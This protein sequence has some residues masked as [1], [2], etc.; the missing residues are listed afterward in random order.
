MTEFEV[1]RRLD[2]FVSVVVLI[3]EGTEDV[4]N[5]VDELA[6]AVA[7]Q[8]RNYEVLLIDNGLPTDLVASLRDLLKRSAC[9]RML[10]LA[11]E[12][13]ADTAVLAGIDAAIGDQVVV[14]ALAYDDRAAVLEV[15]DLLRNGHDV[16][17]G[18]HTGPLGGSVLTRAGRRAFYWYN[19]RFL[20]VD[21]P[22]RSTY[23]TGLSRSAVNALTATSRTHRYLRHLIRFIGY[24]VHA[25]RYAMQNPR[26]VR[27]RKRP[28]WVDAIEMISSYSTHPLRVVTLMGLTAGCLSLLYGLYVVVTA[29]TQ[30][31]V[32]AGWTTMSLELSAMFFVVTL[33]L[34]VQAEY[35]GRI[36][37]ESRREAGYFVIETVESD[38]LIAEMDRRNVT[39]G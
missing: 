15:V 24:R 3:D 23:L 21:I 38:T 28:K 7:Q 29:L 19:R 20:G 27:H 12:T 36:L 22:S 35:V 10:R 8:Y 39:V 25:Y 17:Q 4:V 5:R 9:I 11:R 32:A 33:V 18:E 31:H 16:V 6:G 30:H 1:E 37:S 14:A 26:L 2:T 34:A 13:S